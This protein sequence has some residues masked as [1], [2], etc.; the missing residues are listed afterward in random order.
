MTLQGLALGGGG[1]RGSYEIGVWQGLKEVGWEAQIVTGTSVGALNG[2]LIAQGNYDV[3]K[4]LWPVSYTH[5]DVYKRQALAYVFGGI[6]QHP[7]NR[8]SCHAYRDSYWRN[9]SD[10]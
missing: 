7:E 4:E 8:G 9:H 10:Y 1:A 3:S 2:A 6:S 5:L